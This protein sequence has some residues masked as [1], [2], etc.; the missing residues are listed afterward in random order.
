MIDTA[1]SKVNNKICVIIKI[2][3]NNELI[4]GPVFPNKV[5]NK[6]PAIIFAV[7]RTANVPGRMI[8]LIVSMHT[9]NGIKIP[10]VPCGTKWQNICCVLLIHPY[11]INLNHKGNLKVRVKV[12]CL[13]LVK[14][15]G[16]N[17]RKLLNRIIENKLIN[18]NV[19]PLN[20]LFPKR[21]LNSLCKVKVIIVHKKVIRD[22]INQKDSGKIIKPKNV[23][24]QFKDKLKIDDD[25]SNTEN[26]FII[27][28][29]L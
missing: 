13:D 12:R 17:P 27:I 4:L 7:N 10:G 20:L 3:N 6:C 23:L 1:D 19:L 16:N 2:L 22:G 26:K 8:F 21:F 28:F 5:I 18:R 24:S 14:I 15:Y 9:I 29:N 11:N 25:G